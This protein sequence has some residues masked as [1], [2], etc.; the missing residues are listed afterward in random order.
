M[1][2]PNDSTSTGDGASLSSTF[3]E[4]C[5]KVQTNDLS[6]LPEA[7]KPFWIKPLTEK[8]H[9]ELA[10]AL[11]ENNSVAYLGLKTEKYSKSSAEAMTKYLR[12]SKRLQ[13]FR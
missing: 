9:I 1:S 11:M 7:G 6:I 3:L 5:A 13:H 8:E 12:T 2:D 10:D 4:V